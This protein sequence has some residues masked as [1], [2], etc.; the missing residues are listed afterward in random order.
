LK[1]IKKL[2]KDKKNSLNSA[3]KMQPK[4]RKKSFMITADTRLKSIIG[5][6]SM[7]TRKTRIKINTLQTDMVTKSLY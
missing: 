3:L 2:V 6:T 7:T 5:S 1:I 4:K